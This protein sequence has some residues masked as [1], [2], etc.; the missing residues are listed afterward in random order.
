MYLH[1]GFLVVAWYA[2]NSISLTLGMSTAGCTKKRRDGDVISSLPDEVICHILSFLPT[3]HA[4]STSVLSKRW[5]D[6]WHS[7][8]VLN[9][10][11]VELNDREACVHFNEFVKSV[12]LSL[13]PTKFKS[14]IIYILCD[15]DLSQLVYPNIIK[16]VNHVVQRGVEHLDICTSMLD[17]DPF[18]F[19]INIL[20]CTT[21]VHLDF[22]KFIVKDFSSIT[23]PSLKILHFEETNFLNYQ[24]LILLLA[25]CPNLENLR[26]TY[27]GFY[28]EN[29]LT[30]QELQSLSLNK[31]SKAKLWC[32][33]G[34]FPL[35]ALQNVELLFIEINKVY[36]GCDEIP[37]F[38]NLTT[39]AL[40]S[41]NSNWHLL[42]QVL[43]HCPNLQNLELSQGT[44]NEK[45]KGILE[46]WVDPIFVPKC[47]SLQLKTCRILNFLGQESELLLAR[48][49][50]KNAR[51]LQTLK[52]NCNEDLKIQRE[53][54]FFPRASP[55]CTVMIDCTQ[56]SLL[57]YHGRSL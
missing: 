32:T 5:T 55:E 50:L 21:L 54:L 24:D 13:N 45:I 31:L 20:S 53:L 22:Y 41:I 27:L 49:I 33:Y 43:K 8:P 23:L 40:Y 3:K 57:R 30:Y 6:L 39:L 16:L 52:I 10:S 26:A 34:H 48:Y 7:V 15:D 42:A 25:G 51:V 17:D 28:S 29:S 38:H 47:L 46:K 19:P 56:E 14:C 9:F 36:R 18:I 11:D 37:T 1:H 2:E 12:L 4:V 35:K 44:Y